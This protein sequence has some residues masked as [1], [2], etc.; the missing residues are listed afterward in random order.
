MFR[1]VEGGDHT[2]A[3]STRRHW[4]WGLAW[5]AAVGTG[6]GVW[7]L[8]HP[9]K[10]QTALGVGGRSS[11]TETHG[12]HRL[13][14]WPW[15]ALHTETA[16]SLLAPTS[17]ALGRVGEG[18]VQLRQCCGVRSSHQMGCIYTEPGPKNAHLFVQGPQAGQKTLSEPLLFTPARCNNPVRVCF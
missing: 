17:Q 4:E 14:Y 1:E 2:A 5:G 12:P 13:L 10:R 15:G 8:S 6:E 9:F 3:G 16:P 11:L 18:Q 7:D